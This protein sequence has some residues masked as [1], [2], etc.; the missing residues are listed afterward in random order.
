M[1]KSLAGFGNLM[2]SPDDMRMWAIIIGT[3]LQA[4]FMSWIYTMVY[5]GESPLKE[6]F[7][8]GFMLSLLMDI[9]YVFFY[10]G[11]YNISY[12][13]V[14]ED[15]VLMGIRTTIAGIIIALIIGKKEKTS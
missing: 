11:S 12:K 4:F 15:A 9:P 13:L 7:I 1:A 10:W 3:V 5:K 8:Y 6:G 2:R 14:I